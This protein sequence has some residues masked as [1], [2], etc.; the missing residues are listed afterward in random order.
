VTELTEQDFR[1]AENVCCRRPRAVEFRSWTS[2][3]SHHQKLMH[4]TKSKGIRMPPGPPFVRC[5]V[6]SS[7]IFLSSP[8]QTRQRFSRSWR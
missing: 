5:H 6:C 2:Q 3:R 1:D 7:F 8:S 4:D